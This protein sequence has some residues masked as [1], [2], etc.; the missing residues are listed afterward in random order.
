MGERGDKPMRRQVVI[1]NQLYDVIND[2]YP[3]WILLARRDSSGGVF[4]VSDYSLGA[5]RREIHLSA[6]DFG[7][8][9]KYM[10]EGEQDV[11]I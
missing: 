9:K 2:Y 5:I 4:L 8:L 3:D 6:R 7:E 11:A 10:E 1:Q